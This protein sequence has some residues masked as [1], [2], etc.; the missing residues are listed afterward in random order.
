L[1]PWTTVG[2]ESF[3]HNIFQSLCQPC[4]SHKTALEQRNVIEHY[5]D[6]VV[7]YAVEDYNFLMNL[8]KNP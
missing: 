7:T 8:M 6:K 3:L 5:A 4:H 1:F 2:G